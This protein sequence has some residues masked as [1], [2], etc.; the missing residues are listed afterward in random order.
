M[1]DFA[2]DLTRELSDAGEVGHRIGK[3]DRGDRGCTVRGDAGVWADAA[4]TATH[5]A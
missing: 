2:G 5:D 4:W 3:I 1:N